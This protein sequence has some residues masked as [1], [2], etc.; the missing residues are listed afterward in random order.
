MS[1]PVQATETQRTQ[2]RIPAVSR[3]VFSVPLWLMTAVAL[4][5]AGFSR[6]VTL[7]AADN[8]R[9]IVEESQKRTTAQS[10]RYEG[11]LQVF[12]AKNDAVAWLNAAQ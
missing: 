6:P 2:R 9:Q 7:H 4:V 1:K 3:S 5:G 11:M 12:D 10:Q 8:A